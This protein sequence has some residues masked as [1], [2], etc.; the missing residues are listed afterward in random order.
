MAIHKSVPSPLW[1][2]KCAYTGGTKFLLSVGEDGAKFCP[3]KLL[4]MKMNLVAA[5]TEHCISYLHALYQEKGRIL[6]VFPPLPNQ[7]SH[8]YWEKNKQ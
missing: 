7:N 8:Q 2:F 5:Q 1:N 6:P 4:D 3:L